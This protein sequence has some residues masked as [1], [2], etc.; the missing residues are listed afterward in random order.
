MQPMSAA[1]FAGPDLNFDIRDLNR[2][3][4]FLLIVNLLVP[5]AGQRFAV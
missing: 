4:P 3:L 2:A 1:G 5:H